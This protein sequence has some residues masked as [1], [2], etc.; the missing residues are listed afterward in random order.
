[1]RCNLQFT[2]TIKASTESKTNVYQSDD[3]SIQS[4]FE[5]EAYM[6]YHLKIMV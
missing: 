3:E 2:T 6:R 1:M 4:E 5:D